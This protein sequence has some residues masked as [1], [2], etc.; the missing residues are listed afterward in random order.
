MDLIP[1]LEEVRHG[2]EVLQALQTDRVVGSLVEAEVT[3]KE[4]CICLKAKEMGK[5]ME[6]VT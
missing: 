4:C 6:L 5:L 1:E 2:T 3:E